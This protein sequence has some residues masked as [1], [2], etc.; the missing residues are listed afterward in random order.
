M[1][2]RKNC[3]D[4]MDRAFNASELDL[5]V[6]DTIYDPSPNPYYD[7]TTITGRGDLVFVAKTYLEEEPVTLAAVAYNIGADGRLEERYRID[8]A[9][10]FEN[11][12][13]GAV[14]QVGTIAF[15]LEESA[16]AVQLRTFSPYTGALLQTIA[17]PDVANAD[18]EVI[19]SPIAG[20]RYVAISYRLTSG[21]LRIVLVDLFS[22]VISGV[23]LAD[24]RIAA[25]LKPFLY[26]GR[27]Y[28]GASTVAY[29]FDEE[30]VPITANTF[31]T[32]F[33]QEGEELISVQEITTPSTV[34]DFDFKVRNGS[35]LLAL[36]IASTRIEPLISPLRLW[37]SVTNIYNNATGVWLLSFSGCTLQLAGIYTVTNGMSGF[38]AIAFDET[39]RFLVAALYPVLQVIGAS[40]YALT[41]RIEG[42]HDCEL[43]KI[44]GVEIAD[45]QLVLKV[46]DINEVIGTANQIQFSRDGNW[47]VI[48]GGAFG[49]YGEALGPI[50]V[51]QV[52]ASATTTL[53]RVVY[54]DHKH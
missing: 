6:T 31:F 42:G 54:K 11:V 48:S 22:G 30:G 20:E 17:L 15:L 29:V 16:E 36:A 8:L 44:Q 10:G 24:N 4:M 52:P 2:A 40:K 14:N 32:L 28:V 19:G 51:T 27:V 18:Y 26:A 46:K 21:L 5:V 1:P 33:V 13:V 45:R 37:S 12:S 38:G 35:V 50:G 7:T 25:V 34:I 3:N 43:E 49:Q 9:P 39:G 41:L 23:S 47:A 53:Y